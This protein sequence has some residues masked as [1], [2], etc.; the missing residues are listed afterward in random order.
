MVKKYP[1]GR[2]SGYLHSLKPGDSLYILTTLAGYKWKP[3]TF[4]HITLI[5]GGCGITP[6]YQLAQGILRNPEDKTRM[7][8]VFGANSDEDV[9][10]KK[11]LDAFAKEF[12]DRFSVKYTVSK[13]VEG[14][15]VRRGRVDREILEDVVKGTDKVFVCG[16]PG[17]EEALVGKRGGGVLGELGIGKGQ[18]HRF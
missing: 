6:I 1:N 2:G 7:T 16:P 8:L 14:S 5:A 11:E 9:L 17:M 15:G 4:S 13:P 12:P 18:I 10:L 3:N